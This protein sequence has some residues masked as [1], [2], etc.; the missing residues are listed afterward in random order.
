[1]DEPDI[2]CYFI[3]FFKGVSPDIGKVHR[4]GKWTVFFP[5]KLHIPYGRVEISFINSRIARMGQH[6]VDASYRHDVTAHEHDQKTG[7]LL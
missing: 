3:E 6:L 2:E 5:S 4:S 7:F 1:M